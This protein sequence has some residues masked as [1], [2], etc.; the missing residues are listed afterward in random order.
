M[1][2]LQRLEENCKNKPDTVA[3][4]DTT[5]QITYGELNDISA[6]IYSYLKA[7]GIGKEDIALINLPRG[8]SVIAAM[9]GV[10]RSGAA[11]II[12]DAG[13]PAEKI[14]YVLN[15][16]K[17]K[18]LITTEVYA[19]ML[20]AEPLYGYERRRP[21]DL[22]Y[23]I[24][25]SGTTGH[26]KGVMQEYGVLEEIFES[27]KA[28]IDEKNADSVIMGLISP[29][30]FTASLFWIISI[31]Y[32]GASINIIPFNIVKNVRILSEFIENEGI[33]T[34]FFTPSFFRLF[35]S[36][37]KTL[38]SVTLGG[39]PSA[40]VYTDKVDLFNGYSQTETGFMI[41]AMRIDKSYDRPPVGRNAIGKNIMILG[42]DGEVLNAGEEGEVCIEAP[43]FRGYVGLPEMTA[44]AKRNDVLHTGDIGRITPEGELLI[45]GRNDDMVKINGN[46]V[47]VSEI[48]EVAKRVTGL[49]WV[50]AK[51]FVTEKNAFVCLY[52]LEEL[53]I[54]TEELREKL[55]EHLPGYMIPSRYVKIDSIPK[56]ANGKFSR[57]LLPLPEVKVIDDEKP[58]TETERILCEAIAKVLGLETVGVNT[59]FY[60]MG[61]DSIRSIM[62]VSELS[63][64]DFTVAFVYRGRT[65]RGMAKLYE[66]IKGA[67]KEDYDLLEEEAEKQLFPMINEQQYFFDYQLYTP[68]STM[69]NLAIM[70]RFLNDVDM[71]RLAEAIKE[72]IKGH[73]VFMTKF[74][75]TEEGVMQKFCPSEP[76]I[77]VEEVS[78]ADMVD[79]METLVRPYKMVDN[80]L[81]R[82]RLFLTERG[83][84]L[85][86]DIHHCIADGTSLNI[87]LRDIQKAY[88][89]EPLDKD[90]YYA[91]LNKLSTYVSDTPEGFEN[92]EKSFHEITDWTAKPEIDI[93]SRDN[94]RG[95]IK[96]DIPVSKASFDIISEKYGVGKNPFIIAATVMALAAET[97][98]NDILLGWIFDGRV[99]ELEK[100]QVGL[101][102][103]DKLLC[104]RLLDDMTL[105]DFLKT[106]VKKIEMGIT[107][108][109]YDIT[110]PEGHQIVS[111]DIT[112]VIYQ[113]NLLAFNAEG[114]LKYQLVELPDKYGA[115]ENIINVE[116]IDGEIFPQL[117]IVYNSALYKEETIDGFMKKIAK[118][119]LKLAEYADKP[120]TKIMTLIHEM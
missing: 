84:Y 9:V 105:S 10:L 62:L 106:I 68:M 43:Y 30:T 119:A 101:V 5:R 8:A 63:W 65:S 50:G 100:S 72:V 45:L 1:D 53:N 18:I 82:M 83:G 99:N 67:Q 89:G 11:F 3:V 73:P 24:Y 55:S 49:E 4:K 54:T 38:K 64:S 114:V 37:P 77:R 75:F 78:E 108:Y 61:G 40:N 59:D 25:T 94:T 60:E 34:I 110:M 16:S 48:E 47:E 13:D 91:Y 96:S 80:Y 86:I 2:F 76:E 7:K 79:I 85:F 26:P 117:I 109:D 41:A 112:C 93:E 36:L 51:A 107:Y 32:V 81:Y 88:Q 14:K 113:S 95:I 66:K 42:E 27:Q 70:I 74:F 44:E 31:L 46:R 23:V 98:K 111:D 21:H 69:Y 104:V 17:S 115:T 39:E 33:N 28:V 116:M 12:M 22:A 120:E 15:N 52:Y 118:S 56:N 35:D 92:Y 6:K 90:Y 102:I 71:D 29:L 97:K 103:K 58:A 19:E 87:L 20:E 57:K